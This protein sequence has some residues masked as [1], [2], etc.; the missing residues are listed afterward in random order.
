MTLLVDQGEEAQRPRW[1]EIRQFQDLHEVLAEVQEP[2]TV[3]LGPPGSGKST[4]LR[5]HELECCRAGLAEGTAES[6]EERLLTFFIELNDY[7]PE[8]ADRPLPPAMDWLA[9]RWKATDPALPPLPTLLREGRLTLLL[10]AINE[11]PYA[12]DAAIRQWKGF[13]RELARDYPG[14]RVVF[15]CRSLDYSASL[16]SKELPVPQVRLEALSDPQVQEFL[17]RYDP[18]HGAALWANLKASPQLDLFRL[19]YY[20]KLLVEQATDGH[21]PSGRAAL[22]TGIVRQSLKREVN[23]ENALFQAGELVDERDIRR[24]APAAVRWKTPFDLP[25]RGVLLPGLGRLAFKMQA[26]RTATEAGQVRIAYDEAIAYLDH[27]RAEDLLEAGAALGVLDLDLGSEEVLYVHQLMQE[28]FAARR[29]VKKPDPALVAQ[30]WRADEVSPSLAETLERLADSDPLPPLPP[31]GWAETTLMAAAMAA[32]PDRFVADLMTHNLPL[33]GRCAAQPDVGASRELKNCL[34]WLWS[35]AR[36]RPRPICGCASPPAWPWASSA[37]RA[38]SA[39]GGLAET[40]WC[41]R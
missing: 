16:S 6:R 12:K 37:I 17:E 21:V 28:Y 29:L 26:K 4:L 39:A 33:A 34:R 5:H 8:D 40:I 15:S 1:R 32:D 31:G 13:L 38:S 18:A 11:I 7:K 25:E 9:A 41:H 2:A 30:A 19:P 27:P 3:L 24:L 10:D 36:A 22:F 35:P 23:G 14:N 20:L